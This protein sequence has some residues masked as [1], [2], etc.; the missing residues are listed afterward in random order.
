MY[1]DISIIINDNIY[2]PSKSVSKLYVYYFAVAQFI[3]N[4]M[5]KSIARKVNITSLKVYFCSMKILTAL[6]LI[7]F[8]PI[9]SS[10]QTSA[11]VRVDSDF[12]IDKEISILM[13]EL[14]LKNDQKLAIAMLLLKYASEFDLTEFDDA[15]KAKQYNIARKSIRQMDKDLKGILDKGQYKT[16]KKSKRKIKRDIRKKK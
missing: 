14:E 8:L 11:E 15:S 7:I 13:N 12:T 1:T 9:L 16:Y 5:L 2:F 10:A 3:F 4:G 6:A